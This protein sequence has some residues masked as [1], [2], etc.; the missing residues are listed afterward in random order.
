MDTVMDT[1]KKRPLSG[2][3]WLLLELETYMRLSF[4]LK[5]YKK[6]K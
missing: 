3:Y 6:E 5:E 2:L 1:S 4:L